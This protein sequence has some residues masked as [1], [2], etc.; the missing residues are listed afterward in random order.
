MKRLDLKLIFWTSLMSVIITA[1][2]AIYSF[3][4]EKERLMEQ[5]DIQANTLKYAI[6]QAA[7]GPILYDDFP[8]LQSLAESFINKSRTISYVRIYLADEQQTL[9]TEEVDKSHPIPGKIYKEIIEVDKGFPLGIVE[10]GMQTAD[11]DSLINEHVKSLILILGFMIIVK[12]ITQYVVITLMVRRPLKSLGNQAVRLG[13]GD[14]ASEITLPGNDELVILASTLNNMRNNLNRSYLEVK[15]Q[16]DSLIKSIKINNKF[17]NRL[18][19]SEETF[20]GIFENAATGIAKFGLDLQF[21]K[22]NGL[23]VFASRSRR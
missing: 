14:L 12:I 20:R 7:I 23:R 16:N 9:M 6:S 11:L 17:V 8:A 15:V 13:K 21:Q 18:S 1:I 5:L 10:I 3:N 19:E 22:A 2:Y 4:N